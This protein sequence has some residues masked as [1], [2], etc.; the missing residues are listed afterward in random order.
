MTL[1]VVEA[2]HWAPP[3]LVLG[4]IALQ[5]AGRLFVVHDGHGRVYRHEP[6]AG[7]AAVEHRYP[8]WA[9]GPFGMVEPERAVPAAP[10]LFALTEEG[11]V[12]HVGAAR[13]LAAAFDG[14]GEIDRRDCTDPRRQDACR[15][16]HH[17][18]EAAAAG[19][20]VDLYL[21]VT[22]EAGRADRLLGRTSA[23]FADAA[24]LRA[25]VAEPWW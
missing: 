2:E 21:A 18:V 19:R 20:T 17:V 16:N 13:D 9:R 8:T 22:A 3:L 25:L 12:R 6:L 24:R 7:M 4:G 15:V 1:H 11:A 23:P 5:H 14:L 10:G